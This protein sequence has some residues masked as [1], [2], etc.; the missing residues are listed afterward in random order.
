MVAAASIMGG[1]PRCAACKEGRW[2]SMFE[3]DDYRWRETYF[4][5]FESARKPSTKRV[6]Q[7]LL[8]LS[9]R[10]QLAEQPPS[11]N[12][13]PDAEADELVTLLAPDDFAAVEVSFLSG[14]DVEVEGARLAE[15]LQGS[16]ERKMLERLSKCD[17]RFDIMH[18]EQ[19]TGDD[20]DDAD[21]T[22]DP[23][24]LLMVMEALV[25]LTGGIGVDPQ[26]GALM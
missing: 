22:F 8:K 18:F 26:S 25:K 19:V 14:E 3:R 5:M 10:F 13:E 16:A 24:A 23:S 20:E 4:V 6:I 11:D 7:A 2:M 21:E 15:E 17:A 9:N 1:A 12:E